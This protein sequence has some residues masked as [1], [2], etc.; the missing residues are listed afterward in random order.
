MKKLCLRNDRMAE[1]LLENG[2][3][4]SPCKFLKT[5]IKTPK[6]YPDNTIYRM[7]K[8]LFHSASPS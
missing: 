3:F 4:D 5:L 7:K 2:L 6:S 8:I 1:L